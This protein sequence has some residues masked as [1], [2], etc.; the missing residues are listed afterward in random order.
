[1]FLPSIPHNCGA[2]RPHFA[3][4][5]RGE[6]NAS[7]LRICGLC[8]R[9]LQLREWK[10]L[11]WLAALL[12]FAGSSNRAIA[13]SSPSLVYTDR[14]IQF[15]LELASNFL[16]ASCPRLISDFLSA[17]TCHRVC[18]GKGVK[19]FFVPHSCK[20]PGSGVPHPD[21]LFRSSN[22]PCLS[23]ASSPR[24]ICKPSNRFSSISSFVCCEFSLN[25]LL[26]HLNSYLSSNSAMHHGC[27][28][29]ALRKL[30]LLKR[31]SAV[32]PPLKLFSIPRASKKRRVYKKSS[33]KPHPPDV[34]MPLHYWKIEGFSS[35]TLICFPILSCYDA[36][37]VFS[38]CESYPLLNKWP[39][40]LSLELLIIFV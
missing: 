29:S 15:F 32:P 27:E 1:M 8:Y 20:R 13:F 11:L 26:Q 21:V 3:F 7:A 4:S 23:L 22:D 39:S 17:I 35:R 33:D 28:T 10:K 38:C 12:S 31:I 6:P 19:K 37:P 30:W 40:L 18:F 34:Q 14:A 36:K 9:P 2:E 5:E 16:L 25:Q 24:W